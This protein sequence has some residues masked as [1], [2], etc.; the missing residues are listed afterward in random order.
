LEWAL[1]VDKNFPVN[2]SSIYF[3]ATLVEFG[4]LGALGCFAIAILLALLILIHLVS[5]GR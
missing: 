4:V 3:K 5:H 2:P 1:V